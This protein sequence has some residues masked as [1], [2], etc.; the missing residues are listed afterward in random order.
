MQRWGILANGL[1]SLL[2]RGGGKVVVGFAA[3]NFVRLLLDVS[4]FGYLD[5]ISGGFSGGCETLHSCWKTSKHFSH[6]V[7]KR[8][9]FV[10][11]TWSPN[12]WPLPI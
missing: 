8:K 5:A 1:A 6:A 4:S 2:C 10:S 7:R 3:N 12:G 9:L 11:F